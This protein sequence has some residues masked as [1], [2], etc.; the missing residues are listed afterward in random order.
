[1]DRPRHR[2]IRYSQNFL[3]DPALARKLVAT[4][5]LS[6]DDLVIEIGPGRGV[7]TRALSER[8]RQV[9]AI[10]LDELLAAE[11]GRSLDQLRNVVIYEGNFLDLPL[12]LTMYKVFA[13]IPFNTTAAI[14]SK[15][16]D[17]PN[18]PS[19][20]WLIMQR[21]AAARFIGLG[22][23]TLAAL[24][25]HPWF[26]PVVVHNFRRDDFVPPPRVEVVLLRFNKRG[27]PLVNE[28]ERQLFRD[29][30]THGFTAWQPSVRDAYRGAFAERDLRRIE[31]ELRINLRRKPSALPVDQWLAMF[32]YFACHGSARQR[33]TIAG[34]DARLQAQQAG[35]TKEHRTRG[36]RTLSLQRATATLELPQARTAG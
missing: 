29:F 7:L 36:S 32:D 19:E 10:E 23:T 27:P 1:M 13:N 20:A 15:L 2:S 28:V 18:P 4:S 8:C 24:L 30:V 21:E 3:R 35:L 25:I 5:S 16:L 31:S 14:V 9:V 22:R 17:G 12:P 11:L 33:D 34:A 26:E 6:R